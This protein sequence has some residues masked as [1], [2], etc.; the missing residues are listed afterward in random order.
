[1]RSVPMARPALAMKGFV[2]CSHAPM[3][4][5]A[6]LLSSRYWQLLAVLTCTFTPVLDVLE[7]STPS[8]KT[9]TYPG[10][11][12]VNVTAMWCHTPGVGV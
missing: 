11:P 6:Q 9:A 4:M 2:L 5:Y 10:E 3:V 8:T 1:M 12:P 7:L